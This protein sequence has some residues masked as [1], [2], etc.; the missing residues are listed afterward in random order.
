MSVRRKHGTLP[1]R[2]KLKR[3]YPIEEINIEA[4]KNRE[5]GINDVLRLCISVQFT[6]SSQNKLQY[7]NTYE[8]KVGKGAQKKPE[9]FTMKP[10]LPSHKEL[11]KVKIGGK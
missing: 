1:P 6:L 2:L 11:S 7:K 9:G 4:K 3:R 5:E 10:G 8:L